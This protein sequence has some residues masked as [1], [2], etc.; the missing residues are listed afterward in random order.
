[1]VNT[2]LLFNIQ[3]CVIKFV[4]IFII[5]HMVC[6]FFLHGSCV[7]VFQVL[8]RNVHQICIFL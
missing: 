7:V 8:Q 6:Y 1:M 3:R 5:M 4:D 2:M